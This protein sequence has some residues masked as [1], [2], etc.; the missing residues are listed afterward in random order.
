MIDIGS[1]EYKRGVSCVQVDAKDLFLANHG[2]FEECEGY[3]IRDKEGQFNIKRFKASL[4]YSLESNKLR[5]VYE[6]VYRN[7]RFT[8][9]INHKEYTQ[10]VVSVTFKFAVKSYNRFRGNIYVA[11][12][13]DFDDVSLNDCVQIIDGQLVAIKVD[14]PVTSPISSDLLGKYFYYA[15]GCYHAKTN[16]NTVYSVY[17]LRK[18]I[19]EKGFYLDGIHFVRYKRSAG[20]ARVGKCLFIAERLYSA[21][22]K[23]E[24]CGL[25]ISKGDKVD[26][27]AFESYI[28]LPLSSSIG[29]IEINPQNI[30]VIDDYES[31]FKDT[32]VNVKA[33]NDK[34]EAHEEEVEITNSIWDGMALIDPSM[35]GE[36][37]AYGFILLRNRFFK[38]AAFNFNIQDFF[39]D[40]NVTDVSQLN[41]YTQAKSIDEVKMIT[42][43]SS[44]KYCKFGTIEQWMANIDPLFSVVKHEKKTHHG[45]GDLVS[46]HYQL[47]N[48]LQMNQEEV[49]ELLAP[50]LEYLRLLKT[51]PAVM[52]HHIKFNAESLES[53]DMS[54]AKSKNDVVYKMLGI[55]DKFAKT[56]IYDGFKKDVIDS[57]VKALKSG[58]V[59]VNG[60]YS[61]LC[62]N[63]VEMALFAIGQFD[64]KSLIGTGNVHSTRFAFGS[65]LLGSRSPHVTMGNVLLTNNV[66]CPE[67]TKYV[68]LTEEIVCVNSIEEN[69]LNRLSGAD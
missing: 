42:T 9:W 40:H 2:T 59:L 17:D 55:T 23:W 57:F 54:P 41:G 36:Y 35:M 43:P 20:S 50:T 10:Y 15:D 39:K 34:L 28:A 11:L 33:V 29:E 68:N 27:A 63:P 8:T 38:S 56:K 30:L 58:H 13:T 7:R 18:M 61:T 3:R 21:I 26:L 48:T 69:L 1:T 60:N 53:D 16:I 66:E 47:L 45:G 67:V 49:D 32:V 37:S 64:G 24:L 62:G 65:R 19:Y 44:I 31:V 46:C 25:K 5:E 14:E 6:K 52:R 51:D 22:H 12:G 4:D